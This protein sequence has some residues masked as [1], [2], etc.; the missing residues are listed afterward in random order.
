MVRSTE[1]SAAK[2]EAGAEAAPG[3]R[4]ARRRPSNAR[5]DAAGSSR[6]REESGPPTKPSIAPR[7]AS[8]SL[9]DEPAPLGES[10]FRRWERT[11][12]TLTYSMLL[13]LGAV[14]LGL[15][16]LLAASN[17]Q[18][19]GFSGAFWPLALSL[20]TFSLIMAVVIAFSFARRL[21]ALAA[22]AQRHARVSPDPMPGQSSGDAVAV[23]ACSIGKMSDRIDALSR[24]LERRSEEEQGRVDA[25]VRERT[26]QLG[27]ELDDL[28]RLLGPS[29]AF[30]S[31]DGDGKI[32][33]VSSSVEAWLGPQPEQ[34]CFWEYFARSGSGV[35]SRFEAAWRDMLRGVPEEID[36][37][38]MPQSLALGERYFSLEYQAVRSA[39][40]K[41]DRLLLL[42]SDITMPSADLATPG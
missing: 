12:P 24:E 35:A 17:G 38:R 11:G 29:K 6:R 21:E 36:L 7:P 13:V 30:V 10:P 18:A 40:G 34:G 14:A 41:L 4:L 27:D 26:R 28:R 37:R 19:G 20:L 2:G 9:R 15:G 33:G 25:L 32:V 23:L 22:E 1:N 5:Q 42:L 39:E 8:E 3:S 31:I 16:G